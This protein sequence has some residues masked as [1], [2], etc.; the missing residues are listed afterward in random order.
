MVDGILEHVHPKPVDVVGGD[1][2]RGTALESPLEGVI[3][4]IGEPGSDSR[5]VDYVHKALDA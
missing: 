4:I 1:A 3:G 5:L 2:A